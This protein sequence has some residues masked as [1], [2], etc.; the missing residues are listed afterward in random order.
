[1]VFGNPGFVV[2]GSDSLYLSHILPVCGGSD[3]CGW[4]SSGIW[5]L[6][7]VLSWL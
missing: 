7:V 5:W 2:C 3:G 1:M 6:V 4:N